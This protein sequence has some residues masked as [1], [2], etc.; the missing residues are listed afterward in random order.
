MS[1]PPNIPQ[2]TRSSVSQALGRQ[3]FAALKMRIVVA[4]LHKAKLQSAVRAPA[5]A[6]LA[7]V[8]RYFTGSPP[9]VVQ[10]RASQPASHWFIP[11]D[12][13]SCA[14]NR[15]ALRPGGKRSRQRIAPISVASNSLTRSGRPLASLSTPPST[16]S[17]AHAAVLCLRLNCCR[18]VDQYVAGR[19]LRRCAAR[20]L[21]EFPPLGHCQPIAA[22][23]ERIAGVASHVLPIQHVLA[24]QVE[25]GSPQFCDSWP[26]SLRRGRCR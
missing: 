3:F 18:Q 5:L 9:R 13:Y 4:L 26:A 14:V 15:V 7:S 25:I 2:A 23:V 17:A 19:G 6:A 21:G 8:L 12:R 10:P 11:L 20:R 16:M 1:H 24:G 22:F